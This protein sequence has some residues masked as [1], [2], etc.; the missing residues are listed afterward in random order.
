MGEISHSRLSFV[1]VV[2]VVAV[3]VVAAAA[4]AA[5]A[6]GKGGGALSKAQNHCAVTKERRFQ[7]KSVPL[8]A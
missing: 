1:V 2:V 7:E 3:V 4:A 6:A 5:A 8:W